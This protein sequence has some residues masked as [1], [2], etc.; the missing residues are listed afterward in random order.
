M[1]HSISF[2]LRTVHRGIRRFTLKF[3]DLKELYG[4]YV[5][6]LRKHCIK[7]RRVHYV[8]NSRELIKLDSAEELQE[9]IGI[10]R[11]SIKFLEIVR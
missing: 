5:A 1:A 7:Q 11:E 6:E 2:K 9:A 10:I 3:N 4:K 8:D